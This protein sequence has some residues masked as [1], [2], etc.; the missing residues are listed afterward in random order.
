M[1]GEHIFSATIVLVMVCA[2]FPADSASQAAMG[3]GLRLLHGMGERGNS[4]MGARHEL[5]ARLL[6]V[7][8]PS[9]KGSSFELIPQ[10]SVGHIPPF[11]LP[12]TTAAYSGFQPPASFSQPPI[13]GTDTDQLK[14]PIIDLQALAEPFYDESANT[15]MDFGLWEEGFAYPTM[16]LDL[17]LAQQQPLTGRK[18]TSGTDE[19]PTNNT[20]V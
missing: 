13:S 20:F 16:D 14:F 19:M 12:A 6:S 15:G 2:A 8:M 17:N 7:I 11:A 1:D 10:A 5:L 9:G 3:T 4:H 18:Q